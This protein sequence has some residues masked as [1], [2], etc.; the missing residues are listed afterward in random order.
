MI[1]NENKINLD[2]FNLE[3]NTMNISALDEGIEN[4]ATN[5]TSRKHKRQDTTHFNEHIKANK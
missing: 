5:T 2:N 1:K 3:Y 4:T